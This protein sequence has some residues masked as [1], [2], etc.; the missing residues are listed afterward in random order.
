MFVRKDTK[1]EVT[2]FDTSVMN[3]ENKQEVWD[4]ITKA[5]KECLNEIRNASFKNMPNLIFP[6]FFDSS[7]MHSEKY[8]MLG[9]ALFYD[10]MGE[11]VLY[12]DEYFGKTKIINTHILNSFIYKTKKSK[13]KT[14]YKISNDP[15]LHKYNTEKVT[16]DQSTLSLLEKYHKEVSVKYNLK[17]SEDR[18]RSYDSITESKKKI[19]PN[20]DNFDNIITVET[21][22]S[23]SEILSVFKAYNYLL[24]NTYSSDANFNQISSTDLVTLL[25]KL[26]EKY[27]VKDKKAY[28][29][30]SERT[31]YYRYLQHA[32]TEL[33]SLI[34]EDQELLMD[35]KNIFIPVTFV[36]FMDKFNPG[37]FID[38]D[39]IIR[40]NHIV[41]NPQFFAG[42]NSN[43]RP[44]K[45]QMYQ[46][47][48][49]LTL[50]DELTTNHVL[51]T[52]LT[53]IPKSLCNRILKSKLKTVLNPILEKYEVLNNVYNIPKTILELDLMSSF[54]FVDD[55]LIKEK[56][57]TLPTDTHKV[58]SIS[59]DGNINTS[60]YTR[61]F[62]KYLTYKFATFTMPDRNAVNVIDF[63]ANIK[64]AFVPIP[65]LDSILNELNKRKEGLSQLL[66]TG[67]ANVIPK[68][69]FQIEKAYI[70]YLYILRKS[71]LRFNFNGS[72]CIETDNLTEDYL[73]RG[74]EGFNRDY[75]GEL[76]DYTRILII[77]KLYD[78]ISTNPED[79][80]DIIES[81]IKSIK[82]A[83]KS[84]IETVYMLDKVGHILLKSINSNTGVSTVST[85]IK[86]YLNKVY[87]IFNIED[88][89]TLQKEME[90]SYV[91]TISK[92]ISASVMRLLL[93]K[94][95][96]LLNILTLVLHIIKANRS[97][98]ATDW[99][100]EIEL[101]L[102][103][104]T[105]QAAVIYEFQSFSMYGSD[106]EDR[107]Y[108]N[109]LVRKN[110][111][112]KTPIK[113]L[114]EL[115]SKILRSICE[116]YLSNKN[117][118]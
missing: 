25:T 26:Y 37:L 36:W 50:P 91:E 71:G 113:T 90:I 85:V 22:Y 116:E 17:P 40:E 39:S 27:G 101:F 88:C 87:K 28:S 7:S 75:F 100:R 23:L 110:C 77:K 15:S 20:F 21:V 65:Q 112:S 62:K 103:N 102:I 35:T 79:I 59:F 108:F 60:Y 29:D 64:L 33:S 47:D 99:T 19:M 67:E 44:Y 6:A 16:T 83:I 97:L 43:W 56:L 8:D 115:V 107:I 49:N 74:N 18:I 5:R 4:S 96:K 42:Y 14:I 89:I 32:K 30:I 10:V 94:Y 52:N 84:S 2:I 53:Y 66:N 57:K 114:N 82:E 12:K 46:E 118:L 63:F 70:L 31:L 55:T 38:N 68:E 109:E 104:Q 24:T 93:Q 1:I 51:K 41:L 106:A 58:I 86:I 95:R 54:H 3:K 78:L 13:R 11:K 81:I 105:R 76:S 69:L 72:K 45:G 48:V 80:S 73:Y 98:T 9:R 117:L 61:Y 92:F 111:L 34:N